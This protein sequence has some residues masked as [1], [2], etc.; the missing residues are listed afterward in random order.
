IARLARH[1]GEVLAAAGIPAGDARALGAGAPGP[2][3]PHAGI[4]YEPPNLA[5]WHNVRLGPML[6]EAT[7]L[8]T[9][10]ENDANA[11]ALGEAWIGAGAGV[12][13]LIYIVV[14]TGVGGG[15]ILGGELYQGASGTAGEIGHMT[16]DPDG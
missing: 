1:V 2:L 12:R 7:G 13:D 10:I 6:A 5:G 11:A 14:G 3:D 16:V 15:L 8:R 4:V 9:V